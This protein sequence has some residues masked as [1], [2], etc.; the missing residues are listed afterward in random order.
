MCWTCGRQK[1]STTQIL[2]GFGKILV[3]YSNTNTASTIT[4]TTSSTLTSTTTIILM[5]SCML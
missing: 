5:V 4:N 3:L 1:Q 2:L